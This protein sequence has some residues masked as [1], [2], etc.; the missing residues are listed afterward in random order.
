MDPWILLA[1]AFDLSPM[2]W[3]LGFKG[4]STFE[5]VL[6]LGEGGGGGGGGGGGDGEGVILLEYYSNKIG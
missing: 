4:D 2:I 5:L 1:E 3:D 6:L